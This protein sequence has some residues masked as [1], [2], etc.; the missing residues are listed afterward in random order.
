MDCRDGLLKCIAEVMA[1][2]VQC[3]GGG[4]DGCDG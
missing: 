4:R 2:V 1:C 3:V